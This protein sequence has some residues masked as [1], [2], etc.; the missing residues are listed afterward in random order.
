[1]HAFPRKLLVSILSGSLVGAGLVGS[2]LVVASPS[3]A[4]ATLDACYSY[5]S[6]GTKDQAASAPVVDCASPHTAQTFWVGKLPDNYGI[7]E[8]APV[9]AA[10]KVITPC[11]AKR[12]NQYVGMPD[13]VLPSRF[14]IVPVYPTRGQWAAGERWVRCDVILRGGKSYKK[15]SGTAQ[16][17][18]TRTPADT[19]NF[20][21]P[22]VPG[23]RTT[24]AYPCT[25]KKKNWIM[26]LEKDLG[27]PASKFPGSRSVEQKTKKICA[28]AAK[29]YTIL[30]K[31]YP[32][33]AIWPADSGWKS[34][35]RTAECFVPYQEYV[36][37]QASR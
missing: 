14:Q 37:T 2:G 34:G 19:F 16:E 25:N 3:F 26:I 1:M 8:K 27:T 30:K 17:L 18:V 21:T 7:P 32:W 5:S 35:V 4:A 33:W 22:G 9:A 10:L 20:C 12:V 13:R 36:I 23:N 24:S 31:F 28:K 6:S 29:P 15:F 11:T